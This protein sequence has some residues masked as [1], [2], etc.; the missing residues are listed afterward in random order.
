M[1]ITYLIKHILQL[2][3][4]Q[5]TTLD[6][7]DGTEILGHAL[8]IFP[9]DRGHLLL[10]QLFPDARIIPQIHLGANNQAGNTGAVMADFREPLLADVLERSGRRNA[11]ADEEDI[12]LWV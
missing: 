9:P 6:V 1:G 7:L 2:I 5:S 12:G 3:L 11:E 8:T 4:R 10:R